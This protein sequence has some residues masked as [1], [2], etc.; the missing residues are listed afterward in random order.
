MYFSQPTKPKGNC[1]PRKSCPTH[2]NKLIL[3]NIC[4][5]HFASNLM[6]LKHPFL[7]MDWIRVCFPKT[8]FFKN[9]RHGRE[10]AGTVQMCV[11]AYWGRRRGG[12]PHSFAF[13]L[14]EPEGSW[15][16]F[17]IVFDRKRKKDKRTCSQTCTHLIKGPSKN[18]FNKWGRSSGIQVQGSELR[19]QR[20]HNM[21][22]T[23]SF[24]RRG[25]WF[26]AIN[27]CSLTHCFYGF[28]L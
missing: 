17:L 7:K 11:V 13:S 15:V 21:F 25:W 16:A 2:E 6:F 19:V 12:A 8:L 9:I 3:I 5:H 18:H 1:S 20:L 28:L 10:V 24:K 23:K 26:S 4:Q 14:S 27:K 22:W